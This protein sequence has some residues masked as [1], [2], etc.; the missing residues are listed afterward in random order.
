MLPVIDLDIIFEYL[1]K[2]YKPITSR[3]LLIDL[4]RTESTIEL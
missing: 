3:R 1:V 2:L 4:V